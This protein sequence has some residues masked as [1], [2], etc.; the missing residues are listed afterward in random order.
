VTK[1]LYAFIRMCTF[2]RKFAKHLAQHTPYKETLQAGQIN[3]DI[4]NIVFWI[5]TESRRLQKV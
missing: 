1:V 2:T 4:L 3:T 5:K